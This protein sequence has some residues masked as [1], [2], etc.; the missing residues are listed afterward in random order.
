M[1]PL[2]N[3]IVIAV[4]T[5]F[6][7][8]SWAGQETLNQELAQAR[9]A[10]AKYHDVANA[11]ADGYVEF[12]DNESGEGV[13]YANFSLVDGVFDINHPDLLLYRVL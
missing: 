1:K 7:P 11:I 3:L 6:T 5:T 8:A 12:G 10:T 2:I 9:A 4:L 13:H